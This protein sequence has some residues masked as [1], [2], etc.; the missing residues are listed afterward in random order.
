MR[1][2]TYE[3]HNVLRVSDV[4]F[5]LTGRHLFLIGGKNGQGKTSAITALLM[6]LCGRSGMDYPEVS[7]KEG[8]D[9]GWVKVTLSGDEEL[10]EPDGITVELYLRRKRD[11]Q[12]VEEFRVL[13][14]AGEEA[15]EPRTLLKRLC[16]LRGFDPLAFERMDKKAKRELLA[17][18]LGLD[19]TAE[20]AAERKAYNER[21]QAGNEGKKLKAAYESLPHYPDAPD[22]EISVA[23]LS[24][25]LE[26]RK[27][28]NTNY[29]LQTSKVR[30]VKES[31]ERTRETVAKANEAVLEAEKLL[32]EKRKSAEAA[33][34]HLARC[35]EALEQNEQ[36]L[37]AMPSADEGEI[38]RQIKASGEVNAKV[39]ANRR[40]E[41]KRQ[42]LEAARAAY[43]GLQKSLDALKQQMEAKLQAA[44]WPVPGLSL[45]DNGVLLDGLP[46]EQACKSRR[47]DVS[48]E[49][50]MAL[51]P[52]LRLLVC[53][54]GGDLDYDSLAA[55]GQKITE[56]DYQLVLE[57]VTRNAEDESQCA[58]IIKDGEVEP[59]PVTDS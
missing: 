16:A 17:K 32:A 27:A 40:K 26:R 56:R 4:K 41:E 54:D 15:P 11:G 55:I 21:T 37:T 44:P 20:K 22:S 5:D 1:L 45:D 33:Q 50:G 9:K 58:V 36:I 13:D 47:I 28:I 19:F 7:L 46:I 53:S 34:H 57:F 52:K 38:L 42:E 14:S 51:N 24:E 29:A 31:L 18:L 23:D 48:I 30:Q 59:P 12:V 2:L 39:Q 6:A 3:A 43:D 25:D 49:I 35:R 10:H 8:E